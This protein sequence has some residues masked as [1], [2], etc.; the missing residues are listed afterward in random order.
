MSEAEKEA[1]ELYPERGEGIGADV[2]RAMQKAFIEG[3]KWQSQNK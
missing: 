3:A 2:A 1:K